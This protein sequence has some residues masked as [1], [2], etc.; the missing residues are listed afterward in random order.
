MIANPGPTS[1]EAD[2]SRDLIWV[3]W[4]RIAL[5][6]WTIRALQASLSLSA[7]SFA[8]FVKE[9]DDVVLVGV[10]RGRSDLAVENIGTSPVFERDEVLHALGKIFDNEQG[11]LPD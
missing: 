1:Y 8:I 3:R 11:F 2:S 5:R 10:D 7:S 6:A 4:S 9:V